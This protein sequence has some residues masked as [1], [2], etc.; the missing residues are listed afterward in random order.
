MA[1]NQVSQ[2]ED[3]AAFADQFN[4]ADAPKPDQSDDEAFGL[5]PEAGGDAPEAEPEAVSPPAPAPA[6]PGDAGAAPAGEPD[7][8]GAAEDKRLSEWAATLHA[9]EV[10]LQTKELAMASSNV[11]EQQKGG[12]D[13]RGAEGEQ[14]G[15]GGE[16]GDDDPAAALAED[17][18]PE[19]VSLLTA[20]I[21][22]ICARKVGE[23]IGGVSDTV[24]EVIDHLQSERNANHFK[25]IAGAHE[26]FNDIVVSPDFSAWKE[27]QA[28]EEQSRLQ[29]VI[30]AG[31]AQQ[32][33]DMLTAFKQ[34]KAAGTDAG[35]GADDAALDA[36]EGVR[37]S[38]GMKL[39]AEPAQDNNYADAWNNA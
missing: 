2:D 14:G 3:K 35:A 10:E 19:F 21:E 8:K 24:Q 16:A 27:A 13:A 25:A 5:G 17:F 9:K 6:G 20:L 23:G 11:N 4:A 22:K 31:S 36:A 26:D 33:I 1:S 39:P 15:A 7:D 30:D 37:S 18:G 29:H 12:D 32:I 34:S 38:G 28:P